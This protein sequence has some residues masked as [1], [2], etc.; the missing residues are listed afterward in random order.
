MYFNVPQLKFST[1]SEPANIDLTFG[2]NEKKRSEVN[3][4]KKKTYTNK[5]K[6]LRK[7]PHFFTLAFI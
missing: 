7:I 1:K 3:N 2:F 5:G 4:T 6:D